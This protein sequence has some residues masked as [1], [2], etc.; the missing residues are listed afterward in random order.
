MER[1]RWP[2][3][4]RWVVFA[5]SLVS[6]GLLVPARARAKPPEE[7][8]FELGLEAAT[9]LLL[10][11][12]VPEPVVSTVPTLPKPEPRTE[13]SDWIDPSSH[14]T[15]RSGR[16][17][18]QRYVAYLTGTRTRNYLEVKLFNDSDAEVTI[19]ARSRV[20]EQT[21]ERLGRTRQGFH[22]MPVRV[23]KHSGKLLVLGLEKLRFYQLKQFDV[24][25]D[26][27][28][29]DER[30][31]QIRIEFS[32][33]LPAAP[34]TFKALSKYAV[35]LSLGAHLASGP[36]ADAVDPV[37]TTA[38]VFLN[39][40]PA[41]QHGVRFEFGQDLLQGDRFRVGFLLLC[42]YQY[43]FFFN[44][45]LSYSFG[46]GAGPYLFTVYQDTPSSAARWA[47]L[48]REQIQ[49]KYE[50]FPDRSWMNVALGPTLTFG[51]LPGGPFG[52]RELSGGLYTGMVE[53]SFGL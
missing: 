11:G 25:F 45:Y 7:A 3:S 33:T 6:S 44:P 1:V 37:G 26:L 41:E 24:V 19:D 34:A 4:V 40:Y 8:L 43:R 46:I 50:P 51:V 2:N 27:A 35:G 52:P 23:A 30:T 39:W 15:S 47:L 17:C 14:S 53:V 10:A 16:A 21:I 28:F 29:E 22:N 18:E 38:T 31:C 20:F 9:R 42:G 12:V 48:V 36:L 49:L 5:S 32:R 13:L